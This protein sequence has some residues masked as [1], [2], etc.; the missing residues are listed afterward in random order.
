MKQFLGFDLGAESGRAMLGTLAGD[1]LQLEELHRFPNQPVRLPTGLYW[2]TLRLFYE[3]QQALEIAQRQRQL[4]LDGIGVDTWGVDFGLLGRDGALVD[5]PRHYRDARN[6]GQME[7][8]FAVV[9]KAEIYAETGLQFMQFNSLFQ[10][11][12]MHLAGSPALEVAHTLLFMP[13]LFNYFFTGIAR[14]ERS[15]ASTSQFYN[16]VRK[17]FATE[18][19]RKLGLNPAIL[20][21]LVD[22]GTLLG[23]LLQADV[24]VF[25]VAG[26]DTASAVAAVPAQGDASWCYISSGTWSLMGV[27]WHEPV[28]H[29]TAARFNLTNEIG[30]EGKVRLLKNIAGLWLWQEC[31]RAWISEGTTYSYD[32]MTALASA[33]PPFSTLLHPDA[34]L[35][36][37]NMPARIAAHCRST[38]HPVPQTHGEF[39]RAILEGL[40]LRYRQVFET[41]Q[42]VLNRKLTRI[43]IVGGG[44]RNHLL[45]QFVA[46]ACGVP[47]YAGPSEAT[48]IGNILVQAMGARLLRNLEDIRHVVRRSFPVTLFEPQSQASWDAAYERFVRIQ[49]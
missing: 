49:L 14:A 9:P 18:L 20:P 24:P 17:T 47:V 22:S 21:P 31:R 19:L 12:A 3:M 36:P 45:N 5:N 27:E 44:S 48:V 16:P 8:T 15:I 40:A 39:C 26:H 29:E 11:H 37:G 6:N 2:D 46:D 7:R 28:I 32:E 43:H 10:W 1:Q 41:L 38:G 23:P 34:F 35:E 33:A 25:A 4:R 13:D 42:L 30:V